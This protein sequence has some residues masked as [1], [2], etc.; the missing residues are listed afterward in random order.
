M[1]VETRTVPLLDLTPEYAA[2]RDE[3]VASLIRVADSQQYILGPE[4]EAFEREIAS[5]TGVRH[6]VGVSSG[7]DALLVSLM[8]V[9][10]S[11]GDE[12]ITPAFSFFATAGCVARL[13]ARPVFVDID[14]L[15]YNIDVAQAAAAITP[16]TRAIIPVHLFGLCADMDPLLAAARAHRVSVI[17]DAAQ[18]IGA[19]YKGRPAGAL[20]D[21]GCFS[22]FPSKNLG[23]FG[24]AGMVT[25]QTDERR[26]RVRVLRVHGSSPKYYHRLVGGNF[27]LDPLQAAVLRVKAPHLAR[28]TAGRRA[29]AA[30]YRGLFLE[31]G[32]ESVVT[33]PA[34]PFGHGHIFN[35]FVVR[36]PRRDALRAH[37]ASRG[38]GTEVY[39]PVPFHLQD[40]FASLGYAR[41]EFPVSEA[42]A[43]EVLALPIYA[44]LT[45]EQQRYV[46]EAMAEFFGAA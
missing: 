13:G 45:E 43:T 4:V 17:E 7:T 19:T 44:A 16:R 2:L 23:G 28:S 34:E 27:R 12:V 3:I 24:D 18:A 41:G 33:L 38:I 46:V 36:V 30:R 25:V 15:T 21:F 42:A 14:P 10:V 26:D 37:L 22:F 32:L 39:Y 8:A 31:Y 6:A 20:G 5:L 9:G 1:T 29:N 35:Q 11:A 40:C